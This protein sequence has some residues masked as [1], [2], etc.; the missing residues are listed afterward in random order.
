MKRYL[1]MVASIV[2]LGLHA[3]MISAAEHADVDSAH[4]EP[5]V[6]TASRFE[7]PISQT[8]ASVTIIT[9]DQIEKAPQHTLT[10]LLR[11]IPGAQ[12][13]QNGGVGAASSVSLRGST[14]AQTLVLINGVRVASATSGTTA[15]ENLSLDS[16]ERIEVVRGNRSS[17]YGSDAIGGVINILTR[18]GSG[19]QDSCATVGAGWGSRG[20]KEALANTSLK[21]GEQTYLSLGSKWSETNGTNFREPT[22]GPWGVDEP[23]H[24]GSDNRSFDARFDTQG[25]RFDLSLSALH[26]Q[27]TTEYD[28]MAGSDNV[29]DYATTV[30]SGTGRFHITEDWSVELTPSY[31]RDKGISYRHDG[32]IPTSDFIT[33]RYNTTLQSNYK[34]SLGES[35]H[36]VVAGMDHEEA[37]VE[38]TTAYD[39]DSRRNEAYFLQYAAQYGA[40]SLAAGVRSDD[41]EQFGQHTTGNFGIGYELTS[42]IK[43][44]GSYSTGFRAPT[45]NDL[46]WPGFSNP[47]LLPEE[48]KGYEFGITFTGQTNYLDIAYFKTQT[49]DMIAYDAARFNMYNINSATVKGIEATFVQHIGD[50]LTAKTNVTLL[51]PKDD[52]TDKYLRNRARVTGNVGLDYQVTDGLFLGATATYVGKSYSDADN[53]K[54]NDPYTLLG[55]TARYEFG[56]GTTA[57]VSVDNLADR[58]YSPAA[59]YYGVGRTAMLRLTHTFDL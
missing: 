52:N 31:S 34:F 14:S 59:G 9:R 2:T 22:P 5:L 30:Y 11:T 56:Q 21:L 27:G 57:T 51:D 38:S 19:C 12:V 48:S 45:F 54:V 55:A 32:S 24:D 4:L 10:D 3:S 7:Q 18:N 46:Y 50:R 13:S 29:A 33:S 28:N 26:S 43:L 40:Y 15:L 6:V 39:V 35:N 44:R 1:H 20:T 47:D 41:N 49:Q 25:E 53:T 8:L 17:L 36:T 37:F 42:A 16:I 23:D 58:D